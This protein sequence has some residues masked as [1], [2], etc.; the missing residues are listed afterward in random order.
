MSKPPKVALVQVPEAV[1]TAV[2]SLVGAGNVVEYATI[3][4]A[5][6]A[7]VVAVCECREG[8]APGPGP[9]LLFVVA[10]GRSFDPTTA[11]DRAFDVV[12][13]PF[14]IVDLRLKLRAL[15][16]AAPRPSSPV[17]EQ[18]PAWLDPALVGPAAA[19]TLAVAARLHG[20]VW[21]VGE[22]GTG[23]DRVAAGLARAWDSREPVVWQESD[24]LASALS[25][26]GDAPRVL[27]VPSLE[28][29][30]LREQKAFERFLAVEPDRRIVVTSADA[31][32]EAVAAG[33][34]LRTLHLALSRVSLRL[35]PL[36]ERRGDI[37]ALATAAAS[38]VALAAFGSGT[39][40]L[41]EA[42][43]R[44]LASWPWAGNLAELE[45]VMTRSVIARGGDGVV[46]LDAAHLRF[47]PDHLQPF[48]NEE[49]P[50]AEAG[51]SSLAKRATIVAFD[52]A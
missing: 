46:E 42:A 44:V 22:A 2:R 45:A 28:D 21:I 11:G 12:E 5:S 8:V 19:A 7:D 18:T 4:A 37:T 1:A 52:A 26:L 40:V 48:A 33:T 17:A 23:A 13:N 51:P 6:G 25:R 27:W 36:R 32:D 31:P 34:L 38:R 14:D 39:V 20:A 43:R 3:A 16:N 29:R 24:A 15:L 30:P 49:G 35:A 9:A 10:K 47:A 41:T 50:A